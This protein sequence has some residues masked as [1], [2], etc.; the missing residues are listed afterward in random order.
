MVFSLKSIQ[1]NPKYCVDRF[2]SRKKF[3]TGYLYLEQLVGVVQI[4]EFCIS[5]E[6]LVRFV[7]DK[8]CCVAY[9][10]LSIINNVLLQ[11]NLVQTT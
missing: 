4:R 2:A 10:V 6:L 8:D 1:Q 11:Y 3:S 5:L 9:G 7:P